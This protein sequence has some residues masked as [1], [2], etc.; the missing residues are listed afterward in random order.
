MDRTV[1]VDAVHTSLGTMGRDVAAVLDVEAGLRDILLP[2]RYAAL[3]GD[4]AGLV[5]TEAGL[6]ALI[7]T[8]H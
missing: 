1:S 7:G 5:D 3:A 4:L 6:A 8:D 2:V